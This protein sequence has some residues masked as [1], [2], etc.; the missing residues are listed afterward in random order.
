[1]SDLPNQH[2]AQVTTPAHR[3]SS[4]GQGRTLARHNL[5][6]REGGKIPAT[7]L[8]RP[9]RTALADRPFA[10]V[11]R[12]S[13]DSAAVILTNEIRGGQ[14][15]NVARM[16]DLRTRVPAKR[17]GRGVGG[18]AGGPGP[19]RVE[20][21]TLNRIHRGSADSGPAC[22]V[23]YPAAKRWR[24]APA[25]LKRCASRVPLR[26]CCAWSLPLPIFRIGILLLLLCWY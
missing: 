5:P 18:N 3:L 1:M 4:D 9:A 15:C 21:Q 25:Q 17:T 19:G 24:K 7:G 22:Q 23:S 11:D 2:S 14:K 10:K 12:L 16:E 13:V 8:P 20:C 6:P 26:G